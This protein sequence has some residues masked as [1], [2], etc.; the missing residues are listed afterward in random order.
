MLASFASFSVEQIWF[1][2][3]PAKNSSMAEDRGKASLCPRLLC[4]LPFGLD[5]KATLK[6]AQVQSSEGTPT[7]A[8]P[9]RRKT[10]VRNMKLLR[11]KMS[12]ATRP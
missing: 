8:E 12:W 5:S 10:Q 3:F 11:R 1:C 2:R 9:G 7:C 6:L 4:G